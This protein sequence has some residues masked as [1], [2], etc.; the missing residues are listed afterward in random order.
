MYLYLI[1]KRKG[2]KQLRTAFV[3]FRRGS[4]FSSTALS[5]IL[6]QIHCTQLIKNKTNNALYLKNSCLSSKKK[7][8]LKNLLALLFVLGN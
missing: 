3:I 1:T 6:K 4:H 8:F 5:N 7:K 2:G